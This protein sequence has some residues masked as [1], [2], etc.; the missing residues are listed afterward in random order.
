MILNEDTIV[1]VLALASLQINMKTSPPSKKQNKQTNKIF[2]GSLHGFQNH[3]N[4]K[5]PT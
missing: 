5:F 1:A 4:K 3:E 2:P